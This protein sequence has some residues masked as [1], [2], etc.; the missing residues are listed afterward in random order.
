[1]GD[2]GTTGWKLS[3]GLVVLIAG[4]SAGI[5]H[6]LVPDYRAKTPRSIAVLPVLNETVNLKAP[7]LFRSILVNKLSQKGYE[8]PAVSFIDGKLAEKG[9]REAGQIHTQLPQELGNL[10]G[11]DPLLYTTITEFST[12]YLLAYASMTVG[13]RFELREAKTG[14]KLWESENQVKERKYGLD[15]KSVMDTLQ[16]AA[17]QS[18]VPYCRQVVD[19][20][21]STLPSGPKAVAPASGGCLMPEFGLVK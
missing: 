18:Y 3:L 10:L 17:G 14:E 21:F 20:S 9:I 7:D 5:P 12:T 16:F 8:I 2:R 11:A 1:M 15:Q 6:S 13:A 19:T 4:C